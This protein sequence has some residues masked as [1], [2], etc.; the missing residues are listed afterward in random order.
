[1]LLGVGIYF[2][3]SEE[4]QASNR[5]PSFELI[6]G[7]GLYHLILSGGSQIQA[8]RG[9]FDRN[10]CKTE[11][12]IRQKDILRRSERRYFESETSPVLTC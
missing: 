11:E 3:S 12:E 5:I 1:M 9:R 8:S 6:Q 2:F 10:V 4:T 7:E